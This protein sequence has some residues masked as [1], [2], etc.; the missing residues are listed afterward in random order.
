MRAE[1]RSSSRKYAFQR[2]LSVEVHSWFFPACAGV[3]N[4]PLQNKFSLIFARCLVKFDTQREKVNGMAGF[5]FR[6]DQSY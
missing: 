6:L 3:L 4:L 1:K 5:E 2:H